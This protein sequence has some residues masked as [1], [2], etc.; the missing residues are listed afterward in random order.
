MKLLSGIDII[1]PKGLRTENARLELIVCFGG[2]R[3]QAVDFNEGD[4]PNT[5][6]MQLRKL[7]EAIEYD[8][9]TKL[10]NMKGKTI[11]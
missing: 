4:D 11:A 10:F 5:V 7:A 8:Q 3:Y 6:I 1:K 9:M 2:D